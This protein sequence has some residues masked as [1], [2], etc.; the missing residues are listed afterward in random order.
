MTRLT[1]RRLAELVGEDA[2]LR[3]VREFGGVRLPSREAADRLRLYQAM[4][5]AL[6]E[7]ETYTAVAQRFGFCR[8]QVIRVVT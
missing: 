7:G 8:R 6:D 2:A 5:R 1:I 3:L 4:G